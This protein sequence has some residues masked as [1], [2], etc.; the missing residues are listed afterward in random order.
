M[1]EIDLRYLDLLQEECAELITAISKIKRFGINDEYKGQSNL[2]RFREEVGD[3]LQI[4]K[5]T[6]LIEYVRTS[7][8]H[9]QIDCAMAA[10]V[11]KLKIYGPD[12]SYLE[13][14]QKQIFIKLM[15]TP[16]PWDE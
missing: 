11:R 1:K 16:S 9:G 2:N 13:E 12:G 8:G 15:T 14:K 6:G 10:K 3:V 5:K 4:M 7:A